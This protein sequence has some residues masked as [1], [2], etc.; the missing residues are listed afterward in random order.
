MVYGN[1]RFVAGGKD[2]AVRTSTDG[3]AW[4]DEF[5]GIPGMNVQGLAFGNGTFCAV[6][7]DCRVATS[8][9]G[10]TWTARQT[11]VGGADPP[12]LQGVTFAE[13]RFTVVGEQGLILQSGTFTPTL[14]ITVSP[15][16][17]GTTV[18]AAGADHS[19]ATGTRVTV[20]AT[21]AT[22]YRFAGW[23]GDSTATLASA[24]VVMDRDRTLTATFAPVTVKRSAPDMNVARMG[25]S[26]VVLPAADGRAA[27][28]RLA[29]FGGH[30]TGFTALD[31]FEVWAPGTDT[32]TLG[33]L[34]FTFDWGALA[35]LA[36][37]TLLLAGGA[38]GNLGAASRKAT[39]PRTPG[40]GGL[41]SGRPPP[42]VGTRRGYSLHA[43]VTNL[44][45]AQPD[46]QGCFKIWRRVSEGH[47]SAHTK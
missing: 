26:A 33:I 19:Y 27:S 35:R 36:D 41:S 23:S 4:S 9:D 34:P 30:G 39:P 44:E 10:T 12:D 47:A 11:G 24:T 6:G 15:A 1:D 28:A 8:T 7:Q 38:G 25:H 17:G 42:G 22:G 43:T 45:T 13:N 3:I 20:T 18:P 46:V 5:V 37:G 16:G 31:S 14:H 21:S 2:G 29:V 40:R 32:F